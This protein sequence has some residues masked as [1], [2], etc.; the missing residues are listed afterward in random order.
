[1]SM[2]GNYTFVGL[3]LPLPSS[4]GPFG[5][6]HFFVESLQP[7]PHLGGSDIPGSAP[8]PLSHGAVSTHITQA[9]AYLLDVTREE[10]GV[11]D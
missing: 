9:W 7:Y 2:L 1:M 10:E 3:V 8:E 6:Q 11:L 5:N 4:V